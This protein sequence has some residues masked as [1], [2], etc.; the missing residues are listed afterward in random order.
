M[1][2]CAEYN[3]LCFCLLPNSILALLNN[4]TMLLTHVQFLDP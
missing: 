4:I 1:L 2:K 3:V